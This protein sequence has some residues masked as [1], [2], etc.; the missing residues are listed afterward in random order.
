MLFLE[1]PHLS[2]LLLEPFGFLK[3]LFHRQCLLL[4]L[5]LEFRKEVLINCIGLLQDLT[6]RD[7]FARNIFRRL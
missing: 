3:Q 2:Q 5:A 6:L 7:F 4:L 1:L